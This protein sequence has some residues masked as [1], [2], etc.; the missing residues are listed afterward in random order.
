MYI[1]VTDLDLL[2]FFRIGRLQG[3]FAGYSKQNDSFTIIVQII[4]MEFDASI[5]S[6]I[7]TAKTSLWVFKS[8]IFIVTLLVN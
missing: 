5:A 3:F 2:L 4:L 6:A 7:F 8:Q 1:G